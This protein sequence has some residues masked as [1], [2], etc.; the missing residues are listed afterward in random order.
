MRPL[1]A[2]LALPADTLF[3]SAYLGARPIVAALAEG[4]DVVVTGRVA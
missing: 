3:A 2:E 4:A 1:A